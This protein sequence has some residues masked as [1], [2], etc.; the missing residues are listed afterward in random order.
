[1]KLRNT[2][3]ICAVALLGACTHEPPPPAAGTQ[4]ACR[5][6]MPLELRARR[7]GDRLDHAYANLPPLSRAEFDQMT[8]LAACYGAGAD[9]SAEFEAARASG[10]RDRHRMRAAA[11]EIP[12]RLASAA[13][14]SL[15]ADRTQH[16]LVAVATAEAAHDAIED[17]PGAAAD[18]SH[19]AAVTMN[20]VTA[21]LQQAIT[22]DSADLAA[23]RRTGA[24]YDASAPV[25]SGP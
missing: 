17:Y 6:P 16:L 10:L 2:L 19:S 7:I 25:P 8:R 12:D 3:A 4:S 21:D 5:A 18:P 1:M 14:L 23:G 11:Y 15:G 22:C 13:A 9:C 24:P 20:L